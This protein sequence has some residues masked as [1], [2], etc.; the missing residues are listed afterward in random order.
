[1]KPARFWED[2]VAMYSSL[3]VGEEDVEVEEMI[4]C[5]CFDNMIDAKY[6]K[7]DPVEVAKAQ[8]HLSHSQQNNLIKLLSKYEMLFNGTLGRYPHRKFHHF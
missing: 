7:V 2:P 4:E 5:D 1:M 8:T 3:S 6:A